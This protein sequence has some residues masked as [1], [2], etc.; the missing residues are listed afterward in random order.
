MDR[1]SPLQGVRS[2]LTRRPTAPFTTSAIAS[3]IRTDSTFFNSN[4]SRHG[5]AS[6]FQGKALQRWEA[7]LRDAPGSR[8]GFSVSYGSLGEQGF[9]SPRRKAYHRHRESSSAPAHS[10]IHILPPRIHLPSFNI[11][12]SIPSACSAASQ[13]GLRGR[14]SVYRKAGTR[15]TKPTHR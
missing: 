7:T 2:A 12:S 6:P 15:I 4:N 8:R 1:R 9:M 3:S 13:S 10:A 11:I 14:Q 5:P